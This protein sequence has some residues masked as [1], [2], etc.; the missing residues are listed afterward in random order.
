MKKTK[1]SGDKITNIN[2]PNSSKA[3]QKKTTMIHEKL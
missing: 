1:T 2:K 3:L